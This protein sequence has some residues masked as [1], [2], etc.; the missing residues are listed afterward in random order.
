MTAHAKYLRQRIKDWTRITRNLLFPLPPPSPSK[1]ARTTMTPSEYPSHTTIYHT[2]HLFVFGDLN[3]RLA[4]PKTV[5]RDDLVLKLA[6]ED[7]RKQ[8][9]EWD[10]LSR[11]KNAGTILQGLH[12][13]E[14][15]RFPCTYKHIIGSHHEYRF[16]LPLLSVCYTVLMFVH[17]LK[18]MPAWTD[19]VLFASHTDSS[20]KSAIETLQYASIPSYTT[21]DHK[22]ITALLRVPPP[23]SSPL[24]PSSSSSSSTISLLHSQQLTPLLQISSTP[25]CTPSRFWLI[26]RS[27]GKSL[28]LFIGWMWYFL[29][30]IGVGHAGFGVGNFV[31]GLGALAWW[32]AFPAV[33]ARV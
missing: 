19:R 8:V 1:D 30:M 31:L 14:F 5:S 22:P 21:S 28:D 29:R 9:A 7:G 17:S 24:Q 10:E 23:S 15:W 4:L 16:V 18:R 33:A 12:E 25:L 2:S 20:T 11:E 6:T 3:F 27:T 13:A 26:T 32:R